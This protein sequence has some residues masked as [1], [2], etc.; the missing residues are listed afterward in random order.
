[1]KLKMGQL[2]LD[3]SISH[4]PMASAQAAADSHLSEGLFLREVFSSAPWD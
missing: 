2:W 3:L 4:K 1:M